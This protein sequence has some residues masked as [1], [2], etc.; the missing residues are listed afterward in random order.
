MRKKLL[1]FVA[2]AALA[3]CAPAWAQKDESLLAAAKTSMIVR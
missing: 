2:A 3:L 1:S